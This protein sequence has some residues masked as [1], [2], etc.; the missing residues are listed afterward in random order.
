M[1]RGGSWNN[2]PDNMR[3]ATRN[4]NH[5][6][7]RN[8]NIGFRVLCSSHIEICSNTGIA[9]WLRL[10]GRGWRWIDG[11]GESRPHIAKLRRA[12]NETERHLDAFPWRSSFS[13]VRLLDP[14]AQQFA[15][16]RHLSADMGILPIIEPV[17][18][19]G[20]PQIQAQTV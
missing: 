4:N 12:H 8:N 5:P 19:I 3:A 11:A 18:L 13:A 14:P 1:L 17:P 9:S 15:N 7:N 10:A 16:F 20:E 2:H 6:D